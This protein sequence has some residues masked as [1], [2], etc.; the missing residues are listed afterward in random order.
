MIRNG[1]KNGK[2]QRSSIKYTSGEVFS[3]IPNHNIIDLRQMEEDKKKEKLLK[4][5]EQKKKFNLGYYVSKIKNVGK[6]VFTVKQRFSNKKNYEKVITTSVE[7]NKLVQQSSEEKVAKTQWNASS[8]SLPSGWVKTIIGFAVVCLIL[9]MP[10]YIVIGYQKTTQAKG[11]ILG[12]SSQ[13]YG[14]LQE[15][16]SLTSDSQYDQ[17]A[18]QFY[19]ATETFT[20]AEQELMAFGGDLINIFEVASSQVKSAHSLLNAGQAL[21]LAGEN[22]T[23][24]ISSLDEMQLNPLGSTSGNSGLTG[25]LR[26]IRDNIEPAQKNIGQANKFLAEVKISALPEEYRDTLAQVK[27]TL[28]E[29][30]RT[31][32]YFISISDIFLTI[33]GDD[34]PKRYLLIFQNNRELRPTGGFIGSVAL[35]DIYLGRIENLEVPGGGSYDIA[36]QVSEKI[37]APKPLWLVN[38]YWNIQDANWFPDFPTT[39]EKAMWFFEQGSGATVEGVIALTPDVIEDLLRIIGPIDMQENYGLTV[40]DKNFVVAAQS[41]A[42]IEYDREENKPKQFIADLLPLVLNQAF[43]S[44]QTDI[45]A[46]IDILTKS[47]NDKSLLLYFS[48]EEVQDTLSNFAWTGE[49]KQTEKD[50]LYVVNTNIGGGKTDLAVSQVINHKAKIDLDG[51]IVNSVT[52]T[53]IHNGAVEDAWEGVAN[54]DYMRFYVPQ[55]SELIEVSGFDTIPLY[56]YHQPDPS[57]TTDDYLKMIETNSI[58]DEKSG[59][60]ITTEFGKTVFGNWISVDPGKSKSVTIRYKLPFKLDIGGV[61]SKS[62]IYSL[63]VQRQPGTHNYHFIG[64]VVL[65][66]GYEVLWQY[67]EFQHSGNSYKY[68]TDQDN[69]LFFGLVIN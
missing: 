59:T 66:P 32:D 44:E 18:R 11:K 16:G 63:L 57:V 46:I 29:L 47:L 21:G 20:L 68:L 5:A 48:D 50:Y 7:M 15:A 41:W 61:L 2:N 67:P 42:E 40:T 49:V 43:D 31:F 34:A 38:P 13:A 1:K 51:S 4:Q 36:G 30:Q 62:D 12:I 52:V 58:V 3:N 33:L 35:V 27:K 53:R 65:A 64:E 10:I 14:Y 22:L 28:P 60:R 69:D 8:A 39:A 6:S 45:F 17:A 24:V 55:G 56:R 25:S 37:V 23:Q 26:I 19:Q 54:V 9:I